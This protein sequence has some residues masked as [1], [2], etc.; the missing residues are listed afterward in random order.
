MGT[1]ATGN[2]SAHVGPPSHRQPVYKYREALAAGQV[3]PNSS[4]PVCKLRDTSERNK[5]FA[6]EVADW[7]PITRASLSLQ[8]GCLLLCVHLH[9]HVYGF[10]SVSVSVSVPASVSVSV[11]ISLSVCVSVS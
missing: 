6:L 9:Q 7:L 4:Q 5:V 3:S 10:A 2:Q 1:P 11:S 8:T